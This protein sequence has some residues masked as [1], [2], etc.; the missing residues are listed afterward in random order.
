MSG[1]RRPDHVSFF[2]L[3]SY[4]RSGN[5]WLRTLLTNYLD[6]RRTPVSINALRRF[7]TDSRRD[8]D[9]CLG[10]SS[11][12]MTDTELLRHLPLYHELLSRQARDT[13]FART[14]AAWLR[15]PGGAPLFPRSAGAG[16]VYAARNPLDVAVSF[17]HLFEFSIDDTI[18]FMARPSA[19]F[20]PRHGVTLPVRVS[21]WSRHAAGWLDQRELPLCLVRYEDLL[22][23]PV[24]VLGRLIAFAGLPHDPALLEWSV[25]HSRFERLRGQEAR[26]GYAGRPSTAPAFFRRGRAG[27]WRRKLG[28]RQVRRIVDAHGAAMDRLGYLDEAR[29]FLDGG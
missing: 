9:E 28:R 5:S 7:Y 21:T 27:D 17:S 24:E 19:T 14:H 13:T 25:E 4:P 23:E 11:S 6:R 18:D 20:G 15:V 16:V 10:L 3:A 12:A 26:D 22:A 2:W 8:F 29:R 1:V